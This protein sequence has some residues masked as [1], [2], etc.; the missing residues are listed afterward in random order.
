MIIRKTNAC[1]S[2]G[3]ILESDDTKQWNKMGT[4]APRL[5]SEDG[6][7]ERG[8]FSMKWMCHLSGKSKSDVTST[9][10]GK[11]DLPSNPRS[12]QIKL[13]YTFFGFIDFTNS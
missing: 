12:S 7:C 9:S 2:I 11:I 3:E 1:E 4:L 6:G 13:M 10:A 5:G 8:I